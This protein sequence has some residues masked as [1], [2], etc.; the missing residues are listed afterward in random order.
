[1]GVRFRRQSGGVAGI[2]SPGILRWR[3]VMGHE[4][5][6]QPGETRGPTIRD[7]PG[8]RGQRPAESRGLIRHAGAHAMIAITL[9]AGGV[10]R[11]TVTSAGMVGPP[12]SPAAAST[13]TRAG[14]AS[15][16]P[17]STAA[18]FTVTAEKIPAALSARTIVPATADHP[19][20]HLDPK[21]RVPATKLHPRMG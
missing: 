10:T 14:V 9:A 13:Q 1:M 3:W 4:G 16:L 8:N 21:T 20:Y 12:T 5:S 2:R 19:F 7:R 11:I 6:D 18:T 17:A 15:E